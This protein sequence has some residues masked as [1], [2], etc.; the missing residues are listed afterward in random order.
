MKQIA[1]LVLL[2]VCMYLFSCSSRDVTKREMT[3]TDFR[4]IAT[5][6]LGEGAESIPNPAKTAV[7]CVKRSKPTTLMPQHQVS[8]FIYNVAEG[9]V[10]FEDNLANGSVG[11]KDERLVLVEIVPG[12]EKLDESSPPQLRGYLVDALTGQKSDLGKAVVH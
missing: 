10:V 7:L 4:A 3:P 9:K 8:F 11:W 6:K 5:R 12:I 2:L 1:H